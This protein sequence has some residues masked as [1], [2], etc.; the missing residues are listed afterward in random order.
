MDAL[1]TADGEVGLA[2]SP[3]STAAPPPELVNACTVSR[4]LLADRLSEELI[5][6]IEV[7]VDTDAESDLYSL[8]CDKLNAVHQCL[9]GMPLQVCNPELNR[10]NVVR[11]QQGE[12]LVMTWGK[13][14]LEPLGATLP[15]AWSRERLESFHCAVAEQ[16]DEVRE[17]TNAGYMEF[18]ALCWRLEQQVQKNL[19]KSALDHAERILQHFTVDEDEREDTD[20]TEESTPPARPVQRVAK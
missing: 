1:A 10:P 3:S 18:A 15:P 19:M 17:R 14:A 13:W 12:P 6:R 5:K 7:A 20:D 9:A 2:R 11:D 4:P 8:F 16:R